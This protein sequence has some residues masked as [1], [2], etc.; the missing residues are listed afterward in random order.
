MFPSS[1]PVVYALPKAQA[2]DLIVKSPKLKEALK[3][4]I[5]SLPPHQRHRR[6]FKTLLPLVQ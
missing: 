2:K 1:F 4:F 3:V 6:E 5:E